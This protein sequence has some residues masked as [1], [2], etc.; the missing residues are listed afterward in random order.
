MEKTYFTV[1]EALENVKEI[2]ENGYDGYGAD[3]H[4]E[5]F[6]MDYYIIGTYKAKQALEQYGVFEAIEE[7]QEYERDHFGEVYTDL[8]N[9]EKLANMLFY[10][11]G[12]EAISLI[13]ENTDLLDDNWNNPMCEETCKE[14]AELIEAI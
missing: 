7:V 6:N 11:K 10:I 8:S 3:L 4:N 13:N 12:E 1:E 9:P 14:L 2:L 5:A